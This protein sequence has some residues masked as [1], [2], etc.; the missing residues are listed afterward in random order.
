MT[1]ALENYIN[2]ILWWPPPALAGAMARPKSTLERARLGLAGGWDSSPLRGGD[3]EVK[4]PGPANP[5]LEA[6]TA[7]LLQAQTPFNFNF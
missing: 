1:S 4:D 2:R 7:A 5:G 3:V 6:G